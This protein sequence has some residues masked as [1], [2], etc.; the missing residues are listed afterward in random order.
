MTSR[1]SSYRDYQQA[2]L[3]DPQRALHYLDGVLLDYPEGLDSALSNVLEARSGPTAK[4][5]AV[6][7]SSL[8]SLQQ[9]LA[10]IGLRLAIVPADASGRNTGSEPPAG[11]RLQSRKAVLRHRR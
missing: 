1:T 8:V 10:T 9:V 2:A 4:P 7:V 5:A 11:T 3:T 6:N